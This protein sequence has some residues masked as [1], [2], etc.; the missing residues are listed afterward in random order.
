MNKVFVLR[1][2]EDWIVDRLATEWYNDNSDISVNDPSQADVIWLLASWCYKNINP[3][4]LTSKKIITTIHHI[5]IEK[6]DQS[7]LSDF[8]QRDSIT[9]AYHVP[10]HHTESIV[11][12]LTKK[13][14]HVIPYWANQKIWR[15]TEDKQTLRKKHGLVSNGYLIGSFQRDTEGHDL[16]TPKLEKGPDLF[17]DAVEKLWST[18]KLI[19]VVLAGWRRQYVISR[20]EQAGIP[21]TYFDRPSQETINELYQT[22]DLYP[23]TSR[24]EGG[25]QS[26]IECGLLNIPVISRNIGI[27]NLVLPE[28]SISD[29]VTTATPTVPEVEK[30]KLN[31][32]FKK[33][34]DLIT[35]LTD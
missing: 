29:D 20:L 11:K 2:S 15:P 30:L 7:K 17:V 16:K 34:R 12:Q 31:E 35:S 18:N 1:P 3:A 25:P 21:Y 24:A 5:V 32:G 27:A 26:L 4:L 22:L 14:I 13:P 9:D 6:F 28:E 19:H 8:Q 33:Y 23:V 10:N